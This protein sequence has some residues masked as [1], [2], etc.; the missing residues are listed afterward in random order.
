MKNSFVCCCCGEEHGLEDI[1]KVEI[2]GK[3][4]KF[5]KECVTVIKGLV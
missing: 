4:K 5:C 1:N 2:K 3:T